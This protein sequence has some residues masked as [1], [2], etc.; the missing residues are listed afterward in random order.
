[1]TSLQLR[2]IHPCTPT[3][4]WISEPTEL[5]CIPRLLLLGAPKRRKSRYPGCLLLTM[6]LRPGGITFSQPIAHLARNRR[7]FPLRLRLGTGS[8]FR[9]SYRAIMESMPSTAPPAHY[10]FSFS[11]N[12]PWDPNW[13]IDECRKEEA[14]RVCWSALNLIANCTA[15]CVA[16]HQEPI[17]L[18]LMEP[19]NVGSC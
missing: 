7:C 16:F 11:F 13:T 9:R 18:A 19:S 15:Q 14:R 10:S 17:D 12:P 1:M 5:S 4:P 3:T 2:N 6:L 8:M